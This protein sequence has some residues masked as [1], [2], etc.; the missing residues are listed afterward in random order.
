MSRFESG[1]RFC[2][3]SLRDG[4][5]IAR[6]SGAWRS[7]ATGTSLREPPPSIHESPGPNAGCVS[8]EPRYAHHRI[9]KDIVH[10]WS[11]PSTAKRRKRRL[12][13]GHFLWPLSSCVFTAV[14]NGNAA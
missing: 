1:G 3:V 9:Q 2:E 4:S 8:L 6:Q 7:L 5:G 14:Q 11:I 12:D 13:A 10:K